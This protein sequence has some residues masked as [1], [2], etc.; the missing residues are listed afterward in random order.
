MTVVADE[1]H[2]DSEPEPAL[3]LHGAATYTKLLIQPELLI[4]SL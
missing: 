4:I 2:S 1:A 3:V